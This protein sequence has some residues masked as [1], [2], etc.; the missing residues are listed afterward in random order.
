MRTVTRSP[1]RMAVRAEK[2]IG[3][4]AV[5][6]GIGVSFLT[7]RRSETNRIGVSASG[8]I[9]GTES[10]PR[11]RPAGEPQNGAVPHNNV[12]IGAPKSSLN[13]K[14]ENAI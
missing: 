14:P 4:E 10:S 2:V 11:L 7:A 8:A 5:S 13:T 1:R 9:T 3:N 12:L 6:S